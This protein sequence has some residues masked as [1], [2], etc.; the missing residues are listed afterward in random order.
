MFIFVRKTKKINLIVL[1]IK[2]ECCE[3]HEDILD[4]D[5]ELEAE[6]EEEDTDVSEE[7]EVEVEEDISL[8]EEEEIQIEEEEEEKIEEVQN[9]EEEYKEDEDEIIVSHENNPTASRL[10]KK[11]ENKY[12]FSKQLMNYLTQEY[13]GKTRIINGSFSGGSK[14]EWINELR[15]LVEKEYGKEFEKKVFLKLKKKNKGKGKASSILSDYLEF[16][17]KED[18]ERDIE[19]YQRRLRNELEDYTETRE[20]SEGAHECKKCKKNRTISVFVQRRACDEPM[21]EDI[22]CVN[23]GN[24]WRLN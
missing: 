15:V 20:V 21:D 23:C 4:E 6:I 8:Q 10:M 1:I 19:N 18:T 11:K 12:K 2:M 5:E 3:K 24:H 9:E 22:T 13:D 16:L 17:E 14:K 7:E